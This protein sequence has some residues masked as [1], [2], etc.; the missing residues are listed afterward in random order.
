MP[1]RKI[2]LVNNQ[3]YHVYNRSIARQ[4]ILTKSRDF[5]HFLELINYYRFERPQLRYS[6]Y[7]RLTVENRVS[8]LKTLYKTAPLVDIYAFSLMPN[9]YHLLLKQLKDNGISTFVSQ[10]QNG[11]AKF[12]NL[13]FDRTGS[14]WQEMFKAELIETD[15]QFLHVARY[16]H[17]NPLTSFIIKNP[18]ELEAY[19]GTSFIDYM[20]NRDLPFLS[21]DMIRSFF[22]K[23]EKLKQFTLDN[24]DYQRTLQNI[25]HLLHE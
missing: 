23:N 7:S 4:S 18:A 6:H 15:E 20:G 19:L 24:V 1:K 11:F 14:L 13:K 25:K 22:S 5:N 16:I 8:Y 17:I 21:K 12:F 2:L 9:H 3:I 10:I